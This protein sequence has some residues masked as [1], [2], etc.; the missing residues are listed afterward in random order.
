MA[1]EREKLKGPLWL[2]WRH[3]VQL[4]ALVV[5]NSYFFSWAK[6]FCVPALNC[7]SCPGAIFG[8][9]IGALQYSAAGVPASLRGGMPWYAVVP[10]YTLGI[11]VV[12]AAVFGRMMCGW[13][14]PFGWL[15]DRL[16]AIGLSRKLHIPRFLGYFRYAVLVVLV[17]I[18]PYYTGVAWFSN[19]CPQ[20]ALQGGL[21][22]PLV[23]ES[24]R[25][26]IGTW[27]FVKQGILVVFLVLMLL[28][29]RPFCAAVCPLG[30]IFSLFH[31]YS[32]WRIDYDE[33]RCVDCMWCVEACP[34]DIDPRREVNSHACIGCL[35]CQK[36][37]YGA[38]QSRPMWAPEA[39]SEPVGD[40]Q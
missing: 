12:F 17:F 11:L 32:L 15:Q 20:G 9:P 36:C 19:L 22:V 18:V 33:D 16:S 37:P 30:A 4:A 31:R 3:W 40:E 28:F 2:Y 34:A 10:I 35:E 26:A 1:P 21:L 24:I 7:W 23:D 8:C 14:C 25:S 6:G 13:I 29:K 38:I 39:G 5:M 27:W